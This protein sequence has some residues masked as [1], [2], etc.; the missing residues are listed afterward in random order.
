MARL[1][2][3]IA[4]AFAR[5]LAMPFPDMEEIERQASRLMAEWAE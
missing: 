2:A 4:D 1:K 5:G 3:K